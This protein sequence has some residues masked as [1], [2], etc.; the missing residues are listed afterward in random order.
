MRIK[1]AYLYALGAVLAWSTVSTAFKLSLKHLTPLG[2]LLFASGAGTL[3]LAAVN[4]PSLLRREFSVSNWARS[5]P[6]GLLNPFIYY[7][8]LFVAYDRLRA[9]EAQVLNYTWAIVLSLFSVWL[10]KE[11]F[12]LKDL[13]ALLL[14]FLGVVV[15]STRGR[16]FQLQFED[17]LGSLL[18]VSTSLVWAF[19]WI[20]NMKD[21]RDAKA[22]LLLNFLVGTIATALYALIRGK[23]NLGGLF[24]PEAVVGWGLL[25]ALYVG[26]FEMGFTFILWQK[27]LETSDNTASISNLIFLTPFISLV[28]IALILRES[29]HPATLAGLVVIVASNLWQKSGFLAPKPGGAKQNK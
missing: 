10:L 14:S 12:R 16:V 3:Y 13:L 15:I 8:M 4:L 5:L 1:T 26:I 6:A 28:F 11:R 27:A 20:L 25:G 7:L 18:A 23:L 17:P 21:E 19:Y 9:Q 22:K 24:T 2:L 29:I